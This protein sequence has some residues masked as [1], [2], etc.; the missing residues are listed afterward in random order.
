MERKISSLTYLMTTYM[1]SNHSIS[2][3]DLGFS[4]SDTQTHYMS[5]C[6]E[7]SQ[8]MLL[9]ENTGLD[10]FLGKNLNVY[11]ICIPLNQG[12]IFSMIVANSMAIGIWEETLL[13]TLLFLKTNPNTF[14]FLDN[15][16]CYKTRVWTD[17]R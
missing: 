8:I 9:S 13:A 4:C 16:Y 5:T 10:F 11:V 14:T 15:S 17:F 3:E 2:K 7:Q 6:Q 12:D 1:L